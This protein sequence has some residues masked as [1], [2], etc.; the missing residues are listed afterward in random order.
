MKKPLDSHHGISTYGEYASHP[1][2]HRYLVWLATCHSTR[3]T[4][5]R[6]RVGVSGLSVGA[7]DAGNSG[8][9]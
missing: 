5:F 8:R 9:G 1:C 4:H 7:P 3:L 6:R 2:L